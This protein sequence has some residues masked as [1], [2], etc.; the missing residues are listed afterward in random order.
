MTDS[1]ELSMNTAS[2]EVMVT[3]TSSGSEALSSSTAARMPDEISSTF[4]FAWR[5]MPRPMPVCAV[6]AE[7]RAPLGRAEH[8]V[9]DVADAGVRV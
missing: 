9:G 1:I 8:H 7:R 4:D 3:V 6:H 5:T 2:S